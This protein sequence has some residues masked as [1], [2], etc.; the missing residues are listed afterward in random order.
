[1]SAAPK[2]VDKEHT[3]SEAKGG[4]TSTMMRLYTNDE[5]EGLKV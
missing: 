5:P 2:N 4:S 1:M 3:I